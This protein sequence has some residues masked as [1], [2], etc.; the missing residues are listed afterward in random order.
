MRIIILLCL[1]LFIASCGEKKIIDE[2]RTATNKPYK[3]GGQWYYPLLKADGYDEKGIASWYGKDFHGKK[4]SNGEH[5]DMHALSAA[6]PTLPMGTKVRVTNLE[7][8]K[9]MVLRINDRGPFVKERLIDLSYAAAKKIGYARK[10]TTRVRVQVTDES[11]SEIKVT[12]YTPSK[13]LKTIKKRREITVTPVRAMPEVVSVG[14]TA[15]AKTEARSQIEEASQSVAIKPTGYAASA[16]PLKASPVYT[17]G[18]HHY[19]QLGAFSTLDR[20]KELQKTYLVQFPK[21]QIFTTLGQIPV[22]YKVRRGPFSSRN[23]AEAMASRMEMAGITQLSLAKDDARLASIGM[24]LPAP[25]S[26]TDRDVKET[27]VPFRKIPSPLN[28]KTSSEAYK[29]PKA[30]KVYVQIGAFSSFER[31]EVVRD[32]YATQ[33]ASTKV[34]NPKVGE[35]NIYRVRIGPISDVHKIG[36]MVDRLEASGIDK[37]IVV[38]G[39]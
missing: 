16:A 19:V 2:T 38:I 27:M 35:S 8:G 21:L 9:S 26:Q 29:R 39:K 3:I 17:T 7:N 37:A 20:A 12:R 36:E 4:T 31:A 34:Y 18:K 10:G 23:E 1:A 32:R 30:G 14:A 25:I 11:A 5:Y 33:Y 28:K 22:M 24:Q 13:P 6:H 15:L